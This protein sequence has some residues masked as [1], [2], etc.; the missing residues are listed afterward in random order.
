MNNNGAGPAHWRPTS[1]KDLI[2]VA[3]DA[4]EILHEKCRKTDGP[5]KVLIYGPPGTGKTELIKMSAVQLTDLPLDRSGNSF[6][7][8]SV[9]GRNVNS[10]MI[11]RWMD[12]LHYRPMYRFSAKC[13]NEIDRMPPDAQVMIL[14]YL[15][16]MGFG[17][18]FFAT[19]NLDMTLITER[20]ESRLQQF[21]VSPP[22]TEMIAAFLSRRWG[23]RND[24]AMRIAVGAAGNVRA[25][26]LDAQSILD[27]ERV[28][29]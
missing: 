15:D 6:A 16:A 4:G 28:A 19:S 17:R 3:R 1:Y 25:S 14:D 2:G 5:V 29:A 22:S 8:E 11:R 27:V 24:A 7:T 18:A 13:V 10:E 12:D 23:F 9:S 21:R 20:L 26:L